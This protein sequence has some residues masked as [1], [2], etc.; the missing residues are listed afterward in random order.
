MPT[1]NDCCQ[2][3]L[4]CGCQ[5]VP[6]QGKWESS[7][8]DTHFVN[9][10]PFDWY[11]KTQNIVTQPHS[12]LRP[13]QLGLPSNKCVPTSKIMLMYLGVPIIGPSFLFGDNETVVCTTSKPHGK[14]HKRHLLLSTHYV[15]EAM[16]TGQYYL[17]VNG[18]NNPSDI[19][20]KHLSHLDVY[21][22]YC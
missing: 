12:G 14:L 6:Q 17:F 10:T 8:G 1:P 7:Y 5:L 16:A 2:A 11:T 4:I 22:C 15:P 19:L 3:I 18:K 20:S 13:P 9:K 21:Q